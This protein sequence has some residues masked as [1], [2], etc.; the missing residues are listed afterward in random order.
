M[1]ESPF[2]AARKKHWR[3][4]GLTVAANLAAKGFE[5]VYVDSAEEAL[6]EVLKLIPA[7]A[8]VGVPGSVTIREIGAMEALTQRG[9]TVIH[10]WDPSL[11]GEER[12]QKLQDELLADFFLTSSNAVTKDGMLVNIDGNGNRVS[13]MAWGK[14]T[15]IFVIGMNKVTADL[16]GAISRTRNAATPPNALRLGL[17]PPCT[18]TGHCVNCSSEERVCKALLILERATGGRKTHVILVGED[19]G[20]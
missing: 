7:G 8:S 16:D 11:S 17:E 5:A 13:G 1:N 10:H 3:A 18:K 19:L 6:A 2:D 15:L 4:L 20:F 12:L 14:N 9:C